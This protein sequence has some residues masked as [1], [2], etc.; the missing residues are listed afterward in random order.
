MSSSASILS[1]QSQHLT[2]STSLLFSSSQEKNNDEH[3]QSIVDDINHIIEKYTR[4][5]DDTISTKPTTLHLNQQ[6]I[7]ENFN[8]NNQQ[9]IIPLPKR[10]IGNCDLLLKH[11]HQEI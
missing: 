9:K 10:Q 7:F 1:N 4:E 11:T 6:N 2:N 3:I 8:N 5:L